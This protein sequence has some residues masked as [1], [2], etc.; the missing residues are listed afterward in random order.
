MGADVS[1]VR[2]DPFRDFAGVVLQQGR[3]LLDGDFNEYV[4]LLDRRLR[5]QTC[6]LTSFGPDPDHAGVAWVPRQT[7]NA[8]EVLASVGGLTIGRGRMYVDGL[9]AESHGLTTTGFDALLGEP[10]GTADLPYDQQPYWPTPDPLP[11]GGPHLAYLDVWEREVTYLEDPELVEIA[12][13]VDTTARTQTAWQVRLLPNIG[14]ATCASSDS[15][16]PGWLDLIGPSAGRL[17]TDT[18]DVAPTDDPCK[19]PPTGG[20][21]GLENQTYRIEIH[22]GGA[23]G[24]ATFKW[25]R[26]NGSVAIPVVEMVSSTMLRLATVGKDDVLR[27]STGDWVEILDDH[28]ELGQRPGIM[29]KVVVDDAERTISFTGALPADLQPADAADA[30]KRHLRARRWDQGAVVKDGTGAQLVD[31][32]TSTGGTIT[33][34]ASAAT[35]VVLEAGIVASFSVVTGGSGRFHPGDYWIFA[36]RTADTSI[37]KLAAAPPLGV[38]H[39][40]ARLGTVTFPG[41]QSDC[42][43]LWPPLG[44]GEEQCACAVCVTPQSHATGTLTLQGAVDQVKAAGGG[45][46]CLEAGTYALARPVNADGARSLR[47]HGAGIATVLVARGTA[48]TAT[49][50]AGLTVENLAIV[51]GADA[52]AA[53]QIA[54]T[55]LGNLQDLAVVSYGTSAAGGAGIE[56]SGATVATALR[57]SVVVAPTAIRTGNGEKTAGL[58]AAALRIEDN[59]LVGFQRGVDL[60]ARSAYLESCR[61]ARNDVFAGEGG[62]IAATGLSSPG[63]V[64]TVV[65][66][67]VSTI[68]PGITVGA[69]AL[70]DGNAVNGLASKRG[71]TAAGAGATPGTDGIVVV[72]G[73]FTGRPGHVRITGNRVHDRTGAGISLR[74]A[75][76]TFMVKENVV[77]RAGA[78]IVIERNG[79]A[80]RVAVDNNEV[81]DVSGASGI[82]LLH[83]GSITVAGNAV[84]RV[85]QQLEGAMARAGVGVL[86]VADVRIA[87]NVVD[88]V[89]PPDGFLGGAAGITV[90]GPFASASVSENTSRF[91]AAAPAPKQGTWV[92]LRIE[93]TA[94]TGTA[95]QGDL[96]MAVPVAG[97]NVLVF[98][99]EEPFLVAAAPE[100]SGVSANSLTGG[101]A[102]ATCL[103]RVAGDLVAV[104]NQCDHDVSEGPT[105]MLL[106]AKS[107]TATSNRARGERAIIVLDVDP[108][109]F[110]AVA[111]LAGGG[112][113]LSSGPLPSTWASLNPKVP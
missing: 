51:S 33:V 5:A 86:G 91:G 45:T 38:H 39:H 2:F 90:V 50:T 24:T 102:S 56:L 44:G 7:P 35:Q 41:T 71:E 96:V 103:V 95:A 32:D 99:E 20:Y 26:L 43:R 48:L 80:D 66:N 110:A 11:G 64:L 63:G 57:R 108:E 3:L 100:H 82:S 15:A 19:L 62:A 87:E 16:I 92:A 83:A 23:P 88:E 10:A 42:R 98:T 27:I 85:G 65:G 93:S 52:P 6:D 61:I 12:V 49:G 74:T 9:L 54:R 89:G 107:I 111:N 46:V 1:R 25:S 77:T 84:L 22:D 101:G 55:V 70:V 59:L 97:G 37:E 47:I 76:Q 75:V 17:T 112:T 106:A 53:V 104:G 18:I 113:H 73:G 4:A 69:D 29:R 31:L 40:F 78:G 28:Y 34:P 67:T 94:S 60:G 81:F 21:R 8:F 36:A 109:R 68:G 105:A 30:A 58:L 14:S 13:G 72:R 79:R